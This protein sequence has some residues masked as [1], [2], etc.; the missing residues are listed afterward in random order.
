MIDKAHLRGK[1]IL[2][3][4]KTGNSVYAGHVSFVEDDGFWIEGSAITSE[5][6]SDLAW[7]PLMKGF[8][9]SSIFVP[10]ANLAFLIAR[11]E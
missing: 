9:Y 10:T 5:L 7:A 8:G 6:S 3:K 11:Q 4:L 2:F 1:D